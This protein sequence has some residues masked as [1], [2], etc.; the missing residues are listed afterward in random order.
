MNAAFIK[1]NLLLMD[2]TTFAVLLVMWYTRLALAH[3]IIFSHW[4]KIV[5][6]DF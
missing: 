6:Q 4:N 5:C 2:L 1:I 3:I